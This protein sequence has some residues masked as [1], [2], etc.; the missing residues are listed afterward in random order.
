MSTLQEGVFRKKQQRIIKSI[1]R[2]WA[3][4]IWICIA[5][6]S[7]EVSWLIRRMITLLNKSIHTNMSGQLSS[8]SRMAAWVDSAKRAMQRQASLP[9]LVTWW[10][11][12]KTT[13]RSTRKQWTWK[14]TLKSIWKNANNL[15]TIGACR[16][17]LKI[18]YGG[19]VSNKKST[20]LKNK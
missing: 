5:E 6:K 7:I 8:A 15:K 13:S 4:L 2:A 16:R 3:P 11:I 19:A 14:S 10:K 20:V 18:K 1:Y 9:S 12:S 17:S